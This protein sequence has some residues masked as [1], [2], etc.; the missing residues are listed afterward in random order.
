MSEHLLPHRY[1][2]IGIILVITGIVFAWL[3]YRLNF[4]IELPVFAIVSSFV[5]TR[6]LIFSRTNFTDELTILLILPGLLLIV[7]SEEKAE[8]HYYKVIRAQSLTRAV[9]ANSIFVLFCVLFVFGSSFL[10]VVIINLFSTF[11]FYLVFFY[12]FRKKHKSRMPKHD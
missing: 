3:T 6:F 2:W 12:Y 4:R 5:E 9:A 10:T 7:F 8:H 11:V 1:K